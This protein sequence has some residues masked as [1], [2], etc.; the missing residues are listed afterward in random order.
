MDVQKM[1]IATAPRTMRD[2]PKNS[3]RTLTCG[4]YVLIAEYLCVLTVAFRNR[5]RRVV[6]HAR[7]RDIIPAWFDGMR[8]N[9]K[10]LCDRE[11][12]N[13]GASKKGRPTA[14]RS[15]CVVLPR[16]CRPLS[17][18][19]YLSGK[20]HAAIHPC[21]PLWDSREATLSDPPNS[22]SLPTL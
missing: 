19:I 12:R 6:Q 1:S 8:C 2:M 14:V 5:H 15:R 4:V 21:A 18:S 10:R 9:D 20:G 3:T 7:F 13:I 17:L 22:S 11:T 16:A